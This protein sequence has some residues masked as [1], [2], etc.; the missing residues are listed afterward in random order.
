MFNT[1]CACV[2]VCV[3]TLALLLHLHRFNLRSLKQILKTKHTEANCAW[4][5]TISKKKGAMAENKIGPNLQAGAGFLA[6]RVQKSLNRA[7]EKVSPENHPYDT[8]RREISNPLTEL[9]SSVCLCHRQLDLF[10]LVSS[11]A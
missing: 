1:V 5:R 4:V 3:L 2:C 7:Q 11:F 8:Q 10:C 9:L 6:K